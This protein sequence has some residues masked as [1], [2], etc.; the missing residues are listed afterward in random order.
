VDGEKS[1]E[2]SSSGVKQEKFS[3][4]PMGFLANA[5]NVIVRKT[6]A[7]IT[8]QYCF[9]YWQSICTFQTW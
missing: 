9:V 8:N 7:L 4:V 5:V 2:W 6:M 3:E 1:E